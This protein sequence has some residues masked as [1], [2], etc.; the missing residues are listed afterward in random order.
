MRAARPALLTNKR[1]AEHRSGRRPRCVQRREGHTRCRA[2]DARLYF[3]PFLAE[4]RKKGGGPVLTLT[5]CDVSDNVS[6]RATRAACSEHYARGSLAP[7]IREGDAECTR[8]ERT[9][10]SSAYVMTPALLPGK[11]P[12]R[13]QSAAERACVRCSR[14][15]WPELSR[16]VRWSPRPPPLNALP[17]GSRTRLR[18]CTSRFFLS[19]ACD[20][21]V[22]ARL[23]TRA[24]GTPAAASS[25]LMD[26]RPLR[27]SRAYR[28][29]SREVVLRTKV[30]SYRCRVR[31]KSRSHLA[32]R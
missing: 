6:S 25:S 21:D 31:R 9:N 7:S 17:S 12:R 30:S 1:R 8:D 11:E 10:S 28:Q 23:R 13:M 26:P 4:P 14:L 3:F 32:R 24:R 19:R 27:G 2:R 5:G 18:T 20:R 16:I 22:N 15:S 29:T